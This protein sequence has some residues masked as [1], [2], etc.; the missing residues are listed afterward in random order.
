MKEKTVCDSHLR[1]NFHSNNHSVE[2]CYKQ[3]AHR[4]AFLFARNESFMYNAK[5]CRCVCASQECLLQ[6]AKKPKTNA[7][8]DLYQ[9]KAGE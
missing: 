7:N 8:Y 3:C 5:G 2:E 9:I 4:A 6:V 1:D